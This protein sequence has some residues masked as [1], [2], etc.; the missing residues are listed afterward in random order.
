MKCPINL[1]PNLFQLIFVETLA[2]R[3]H[4]FFKSEGTSVKIAFVDALAVV[5]SKT[6]ENYR[7]VI[8]KYS[9]NVIRLTS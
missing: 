3:C 7:F 9:K 4:Y 5:R 2:V 6:W 8:D 1:Q